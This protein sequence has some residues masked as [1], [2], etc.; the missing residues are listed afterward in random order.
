MIEP[1]TVNK[2]DSCCLHRSAAERRGAACV[3]AEV[4]EIE[5][6]SRRNMATNAANDVNRVKPPA[7]R[8]TTLASAEAQHVAPAN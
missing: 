7:S 4:G 5:S 1:Q 3:W 2:G 8:S 6:S